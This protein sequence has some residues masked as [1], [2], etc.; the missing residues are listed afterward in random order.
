MRT[1]HVGGEAIQS[2][3]RI[4]D[5]Y[6]LALDYTRCMMTFLLFHPEPREV[7]M[8]GLGGGSLAKFF[9]RKLRSTRVRI[10]ELD[11]RVIAA[12]RE[13]FALPPDGARLKVEVG[14][15]AEA[16]EPECCDVL[17]VDA[18]EDELHVPRLASREFYDGAFLALAEPGA[19]V[20]NFMD[21]DPK[22]DPTLERLK[23]AFG[24]AVLA[25]RALYDPNILVVALKGAPPRIAWS[26]LRERAAELESRFGLPFARYVSRLRGMNPCTTAELIIAP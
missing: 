12:A 21:D 6:A 5:P 23:R 14:D 13:H 16:L 24:G 8:I 7:L 10:V 25:M 11:A 20:V 22:L 3:M 19:L 1:L 17:I 9:H 2:S 15:G 4:E 18:F 26:S